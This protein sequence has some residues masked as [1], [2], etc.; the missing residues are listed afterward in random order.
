ML[1]RYLSYILAAFAVLTVAGCADDLTV[2][3]DGVM[4]RLEITDVSPGVST[5]AVPADLEKPVQEMFHL[6]IVSAES[7]RT[8]YDDAFQSS[9]GPFAPG[10]FALSVNCGT[11][12]LALDAPCYAGTATASIYKG[13]HNVISID[14]R[15]ANAL[16]SIAYQAD[17]REELDEVFESYG[18]TFTLDDKE[19]SIDGP[20][21][22]QS[23][24]FPAG[25]VPQV[26]FHAVRKDDQRAVS[27][28]LD[29]A[30]A[31]KLPLEAGQHAKVTLGV[32]ADRVTITKVDVEEVTIAET[33]PPSWLPKPKTSVSGFDADGTLHNVETNTTG[34][35]KAD[36]TTS[37]AL[38]DVELTLD[39]QDPAYAHL[40]GT[41][42]LSQ[43]SAEEIETLRTAG[44]ELP[45]LGTEAGTIT[46]TRFATNLQTDKGAETTNTLALRVKAN[47]RWDTESP[48]TYSIVVEKPVFGA[49]VLPGN[50][51]TREFTISSLR[52]ED[53]TKGNFD[54][55]SKSITY[56]IQQPDGTWTTLNERTAKNLTPATAYTI[57]VCY[58]GCVYSD[59]MAVNTFPITPLRN[60][61]FDDEQWTEDGK[62]F[63]AFSGHGRRFYFPGWATLNE[64]TADDCGI[65]TYA[66][67]SRSGT[68]PTGTHD[69]R[70]LKLSDD[71]VSG[72]AL[73]LGTVSWGQGGTTYNPKHK[74]PAELFLGTLDNVNHDNDTAD[75]NYGIVFNSHPTAITFFYK[76]TAYGSDGAVAEIA[77]YNDD[78]LLG[79]GKAK[80]GNQGNWTQQTLEL[81]YD[82]DESKLKLMPNK[83]VVKFASGESTEAER[84]TIS[85]FIGAITN[86]FYTGSQLWLDEIALVYD[87]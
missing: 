32:N 62:D 71:A 81:T 46:L 57:R 36:F 24:Y 16:M 37:S 76:Y 63:D 54:V 39:I 78:T 6:A 42:L 1:K 3:P 85:T 51:W 79:E 50:I 52:A 19:V 30:L 4:L 10:R 41:H 15:V 53:V 48:Q 67:N 66:Y 18:V 8:V 87:K 28:S 9:V 7:G 82:Q 5:R 70:Y 27:V 86:C 23:A 84:V 59:P 26:T 65:T 13:L 12:E 34:E 49:R 33:I 45:T 11:D 69:S 22:T 43:M 80:Y 64:L 25:S 20:D 56:Q 21:A 31:A 68:R 29:A 75:K 38:Q 60:G 73:W 83:L 77:L 17:G 72:T 47:D 58:R 44:I 14:A 61:N 35:V 74:S 2:N 40:S 55:L